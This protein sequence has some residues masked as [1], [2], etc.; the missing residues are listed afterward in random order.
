[1]LEIRD[2]HVYYGDMQ[3]LRGVS[4][5]VREGE[6]VALVGANG[7]G[8]TTTLRTISGLLRPRQGEVR[9]LGRPIHTLPAHA[10]VDLGISHVPEGRGLFPMMTV[11]ENLLLGAHLPRVRSERRR[12]LEQEI[13]PMFP[14]LKERAGQLAG[15]LSGGEQQMVAIARGLMSRPK[16]LI[17]DEPSL[18]LAPVIVKEM[19][20]I[21]RR[22]REAGVTVM[23]VEQNVMQ[24]L[25]LAD[26][27]YVVENGEV[28]LS[29]E[30]RALLEDEHI[31]R[32]YLGM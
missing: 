29:G 26:R 18:G 14:R 6:V 27:A 10:I 25:Q 22:V 12:M 30:S 32:A 4:M 5:E 19:F 9:F 2:I 8:K 21:I 24:T 20:N 23:I 28:V 11:E 3:A 1:M 7:A 13:Y 16:L 15:T 17:L 31:K